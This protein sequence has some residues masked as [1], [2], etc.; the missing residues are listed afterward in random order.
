MPAGERA[1]ARDPALVDPYGIRAS[2]TR[3][4]AWARRGE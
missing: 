2:E 4:R 3:A 1:E